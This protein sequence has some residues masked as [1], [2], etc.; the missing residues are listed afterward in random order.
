MRFPRR[1]LSLGLPSMALG[2]MAFSYLLVPTGASADVLPMWP[3]YPQHGYA[4]LARY[5]SAVTIY[6]VSDRC[7]PAELGAMNNIKIST[8]GS[9]PE[10]RGAWPNG[11]PMYRQRCD[12]V[13]TY[14]SDI[15]LRL[16]ERYGLVQCGSRKWPWRTCSLLSSGTGLLRIFQQPQSVWYPSKPGSYPRV[17][18]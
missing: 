11:I 9:L 15:N 1:L 12:G 5:S 14:S 7:K 4:W 13:V 3:S 2:F 16:Y 18:V 10:F 8:Q 17:A 6:L